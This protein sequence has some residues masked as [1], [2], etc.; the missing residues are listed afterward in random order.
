[1]SF[2]SS[3]LSSYIGGTRKTVTRVT[4]WSDM[5]H[6]HRGLIEILQCFVMSVTGLTTF[7]F[8]Y[9]MRNHSKFRVAV[10]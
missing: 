1:M 8:L 6:P 9:S 5:A 4:R 3:S 7:A 2:F 10:S